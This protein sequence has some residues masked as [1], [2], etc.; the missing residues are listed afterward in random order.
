MKWT[1]GLDEIIIASGISSCHLYYQPLLFTVEATMIIYYVLIRNE[2]SSTRLMYWEMMQEQ[3]LRR[4]KMLFMAVGFFFL[5][6]LTIAISQRFHS[7]YALKRCWAMDGLPAANSRSSVTLLFLSISSGK[8]ISNVLN[9]GPKC[10]H[11]KIHS[12]L[13]V[14]KAA[15]LPMDCSNSNALQTLYSLWPPYFSFSITHTSIQRCSF[16]TESTVRA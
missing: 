4:G 12:N 13:R 2:T 16:N 1:A 11:T 8:D 3:Q 14:T 9:T 7:S 6:G 5:E 10:C 15:P